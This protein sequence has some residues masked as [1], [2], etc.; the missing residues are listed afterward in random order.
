MIQPPP[1]IYTTNRQRT[2]VLTNVS[3]SCTGCHANLINPPGFVMENYDAIGKWQVTDPL[4]GAI[5]ATATVNFGNGY[6]KHVYNAQELMQEIAR[7]PQAQR[8]YAA[9]MVAFGYGR[10][11]NANDA[12]VVDQLGAKLATDGYTILDLIADLT[13]PDSFRL[14]VKA[15]P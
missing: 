8:L 10:D 15:T 2:E 7:L 5:D 12:C 3:A 11:A 4:G 14:R 9:N 6:V 13:Q 1:G